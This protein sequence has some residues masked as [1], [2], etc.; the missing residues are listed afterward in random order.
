MRS[1][2]PSKQKPASCAEQRGLSLIEL[3]M[4]IAL[5]GISLAGVLVAYNQAVRGSADPMVRKQAVAVAESL[6]HEV[7]M[8]PLSWCDPQDPAND[9]DTPPASGAACTGGSANSQDKGGG[10]LG[11]QPATES[12][13]SATD[14]FDNVAD[15]NGFSM[16]PGI[17]AVD[18]TPVG[19]LNDYA[20]SV[21]V[22]RDGASFGLAADAVL[23]VDV[24]VTGRGQ[25]ITLT[26]W[27]F[28][29]SPQ[30][31]G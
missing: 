28:R 12:R 11:P 31:T 3:V 23:R 30:A 18:G 16:G 15:Y 5:V 29:H 27:R 8:Q 25:S 19:A 17:T 4:F 2:S 7:L 21:S 1:R 13:A 14:P 26:G 10:P 6:L 22:Q 24:L 9:A 20:A